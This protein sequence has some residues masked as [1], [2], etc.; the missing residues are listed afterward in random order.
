MNR[1]LYI[2][3]KVLP[4]QRAA[5]WAALAALQARLV[6]E[7][8]GLRARALERED[9]QR[10]VTVMEIYE[11]PG[12][13]DAALQDRIEAGIGQGLHAHCDGSRH[14]EVFVEHRQDA[15]GV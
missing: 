6:D 12:G 14:V 5:A 15:P 7:V 10:P 3:W 13:V 8:P 9:P 4:G 2:Y 11:R 1:A